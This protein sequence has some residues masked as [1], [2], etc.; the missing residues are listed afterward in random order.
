MNDLYIGTSGYSYKDWE[1]VF[2]PA[3]IKPAGYL[4]F[5]GRFFNTVEINS[6]Y[7]SIPVND[8]FYKMERKT[9]QGFLFS[10]KAHSSMTHTK[11]ASK[12][13]IKYFK[14]ALE[15]LIKNAKM[16]VLLFQFP[17]SFG[18]NLKNLDYLKELKE[19]FNSFDMVFEFRNIGWVRDSVM[20]F[21]KNQNIGFCNVD[22]PDLPGL[23]PKTNFVTN[24]YF[25]L[26][27]HGRNKQ[28]WWNHK[29]A[30]ERYDYMY[31]T[32]EL[33]SWVP[34]IKEASDKTKK[35]LIYFNNHFKAK[36]VNSALMLKNLL[37]K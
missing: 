2:Y 4:D 7:Y 33:E 26:R 35:S 19:V 15:A 31:K 1:I 6:T 20:D 8:M 21:L 24:D 23:M 13:M 29:E 5:Y 10:I 25:Y 37:L 22:E 32:E 12:D 36:S 18:Y 30:Y 11:D 28:N 27:F 16:G 34:K 17:Y 14:I 9:P 3:G